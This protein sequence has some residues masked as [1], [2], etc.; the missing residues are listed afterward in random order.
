[1]LPMNPV[2]R[3]KSST[4]Q[5]KRRVPVRY[6]AVDD[7]PFVW[8]SLHTDSLTVAK[9]KAPVIW[10]QMIE[11]WEAKLAGATGDADQILAAAKELAAKRG[12][13]YL[14]APEVAK[15]PLDDLLERIEAVGSKR[16]GKVDL[17]D[18]DALLGTAP[19]PKITVQRALGLFWVL[20]KDKAIGKS[21]DQARR[22]RNPWIK[23]AENFCQAVG[24]L[25]IADITTADLFTFRNWWI[26]RITAKGLTEN[27]A[28]K[29]LIHITAILR[30]VAQA[31]DIDL[32]F[33]TRGLALKERARETRRP[34]TRDQ[35]QD[36]LL[37]AGVLD[38]LNPQAR[39]ILL[40]MINTGARPSELAS[41]SA[42]QIVLDDPVPHIS[43]EGIGRELKSDYARRKIPLLGVS[44][45]A[46]QRNPAGFPRYADNP[47]LS[48]TVNKFLREN[49]LLPTPGHTMYSLRHGFEDRMLAAGVDERVRR[50][51][52]GHRLTRERY[53]DGAS[54]V[55]K[56]DLLIPIAL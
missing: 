19:V 25:D 30:R 36:N 39:D 23:A 20:S 15:L 50:D 29:D 17:Q 1:M 18:A 52:M 40:I 14:A 5:I 38:G 35:I 27:S 12:F 7:R 28:N 48:D 8:L 2:T 21:P 49:G 3:G 46:A 44:L 24:N 9:Q 4:Y 43:I 16:G 54:L 10:A 13:R 53:G 51:L 42:A 11:A 47:A 41:L 34:F 6:G 56:R 37:C 32:K 45:E 31:N 26:D 22:W 33:Q 55:M